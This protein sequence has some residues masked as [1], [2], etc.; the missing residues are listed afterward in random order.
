MFSFALHAQEIEGRL[1]HPIMAAGEDL[2]LPPAITERMQ[3][4]APG[5]ASYGEERSSCRNKASSSSARV[6]E[7]C[8]L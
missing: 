7:V 8:L 6:R 3:Q 1:K 2:S 4:G 5:H